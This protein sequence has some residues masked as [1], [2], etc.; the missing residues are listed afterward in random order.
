VERRRDESDLKNV[1]CM[2]VNTSEDQG[3]A[4]MSVISASCDILATCFRG[5]GVCSVC[6]LVCWWSSFFKAFKFPM[7]RGTPP[8]KKGAFIFSH[9]HSL[10]HRDTHHRKEKVQCDSSFCKEV[11][12]KTDAARG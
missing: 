3:K 9:W 11:T 12:I 1:L 6:V 2:Y 10:G 7:L 4:R 5:G 8:Q